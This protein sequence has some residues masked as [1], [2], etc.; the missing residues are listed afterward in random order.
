[1]IYRLES[2]CVDEFEDWVEVFLANEVD[3]VLDDIED[4]LSDAL[5]LI[6]KID[7]VEN[8]SKCKSILKEIIMKL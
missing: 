6:E 3:E 1:M 5:R 8:V 2:S 4:K 7:G